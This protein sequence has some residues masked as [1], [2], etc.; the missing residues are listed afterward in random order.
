M[1]LLSKASIIFVVAAL[2]TVPMQAQVTGERTFDSGALVGNGFGQ[3]TSI[4]TASTL[5]TTPTAGA[6]M[7]PY[8]SS[9]ILCA[10]G[11]DILYRTDGVNPTA[12]VGMLVQ[13]GRCLSVTNRWSYLRAIRF[14]GA[15]TAATL[16]VEYRW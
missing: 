8:A 14:I 1:R 13:D 2:L 6:A 15:T 12:T 16:R 11:G 9:A 5:A 10:D 4:T 7:H 3:Y